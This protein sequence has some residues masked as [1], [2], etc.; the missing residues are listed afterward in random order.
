MKNISVIVIMLVMILSCKSKL[1]PREIGN[2]NYITTAVDMRDNKYLVTAWGKGTSENEALEEAMRN[3]VKDIL[4]KGLTQGNPNVRVM[5]VFL[6]HD[7]ESKN[8]DFNASFFKTDGDYLNYVVLYN[9]PI[10]QNRSKKTRKADKVLN[11]AFDFQL[12]VNRE[13]LVSDLKNNGI[14]K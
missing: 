2:Y 1:K 14:I 9:Q 11:I 13:K 4:Y 12:L 5:P 8:A 7:A 10:S 6:I 3:A